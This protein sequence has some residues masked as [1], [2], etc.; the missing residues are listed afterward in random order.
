MKPG[1]KGNKLRKRCEVIEG[2]CE[3]EEPVVIVSVIKYFCRLEVCS[4][5]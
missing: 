4:G 1:E 2:Y 3:C 5:D